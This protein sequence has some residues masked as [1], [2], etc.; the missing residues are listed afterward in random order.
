[1]PRMRS[2]VFLRPDAASV[3]APH[4]KPGHAAHCTLTGGPPYHTASAVFSPDH[5]HNNKQFFKSY[6]I[7]FNRGIFRFASC[8]V[9]L[10]VSACQMSAT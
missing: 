7:C 8:L 3:L 9:L 6:V 4:T 2:R 5:K 10:S 1:V